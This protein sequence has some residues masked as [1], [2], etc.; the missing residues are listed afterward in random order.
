MDFVDDV[1]L[2]RCGNGCDLRFFAQG[3]DVVNAVVAGGINLNDIQV[4]G[5][6]VEIGR[7]SCRERV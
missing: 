4:R 7:A 1:D 2:F 3:A 5:L 6:E